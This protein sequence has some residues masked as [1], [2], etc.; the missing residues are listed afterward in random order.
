[1]GN[2]WGAVEFWLHTKVAS[3]SSAVWDAQRIEQTYA[4]GH[5]VP[6]QH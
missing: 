5:L 4:T 1:M 2:R 3:Y 6:T